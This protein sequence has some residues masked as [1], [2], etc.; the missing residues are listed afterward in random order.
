MQAFFGALAAVG[1]VLI[2]LIRDFPIGNEN[3]R[4]IRS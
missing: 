4:V 3:R 1:A 2:D